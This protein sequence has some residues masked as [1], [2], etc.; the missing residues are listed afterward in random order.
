[1]FIRDTQ[2]NLYTGFG[3]QNVESRGKIEIT[4]Y[5]NDRSKTHENKF[6]VAEQGPFDL[7]LGRQFMFSEKIFIFNQAALVLRAAP[8]SAPDET[9]H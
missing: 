3:N 6:L 4:W 5:A 9:T 1:M 8:S 2:S 7:L